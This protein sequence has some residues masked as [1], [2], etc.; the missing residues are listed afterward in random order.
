[1]KRKF[2]YS[3][4]IAIAARSK[5]AA[6]LVETVNSLL[7]TYQSKHNHFG[8]SMTEAFA[9]ELLQQPVKT[10][11]E[12]LK[13]NSPLKPIAGKPIDLVKLAELTGID[14]EGFM[15][16]FNVVLPGSRNQYNRAGVKALF[17]LKSVDL[18]LLTWNEGKFTVNQEVLDQQ[19]ERYKV[20]AETPAELKEVEFWENLCDL[21]NEAKGKL[22]M[23]DQDVN[24][25]C[26][27]L[28]LQDPLRTSE[29][30]VYGKF[31]PDYKA[32]AKKITELKLQVN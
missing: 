23:I 8:M 6:E 1:M 18:E 22:K 13:V 16:D 29:G 11:D 30:A 17:S 27:M 28:R 10:F 14:R 32:M 20:Y 2:I 19:L 9:L 3:N 7:N 21:L 31:K 4:E 12:L 5:Y 26:S 15:N 25:I 24:I